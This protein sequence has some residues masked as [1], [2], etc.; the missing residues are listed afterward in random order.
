MN[1]AD[2]LFLIGLGFILGMLFTILFIR[3]TIKENEEIANEKLKKLKSEIRSLEVN[4]SDL[5]R[6]ERLKDRLIET[7]NNLIMRGSI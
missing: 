4:I 7:A 5:E 3:H 6:R 2:Q 1:L